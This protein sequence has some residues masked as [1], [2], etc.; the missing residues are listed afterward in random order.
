MKWLLVFLLLLNVGLLGY[1]NADKQEPDYF[2]E[3]GKQNAPNVGSRRD[4]N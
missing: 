4:Q 2:K 1:F 3:N